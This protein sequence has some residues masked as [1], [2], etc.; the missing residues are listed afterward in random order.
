MREIAV[1]QSLPTRPL[2]RRSGLRTAAAAIVLA[3]ALTTAI[4]AGAQIEEIIVISRK[5]EERLQDVPIAVEAVSGEDI[6]RKGLTDIAKLAEQSASIKFD[7]GSSRQDTRLSIRGISPTRGRQNA[8]ILVDGIDISGE[9]VN[10]SGGSFNLSQQLLSLQRVEFLKGPQ[11]AL[12]GRSAFN[13]AVNFVTK[14]PTDIWE[15]TLNADANLE[16]QYQLTGEFSGPIL[17]EKL[18]IIVNGAW[19]DRDG[20]HDNSI[21]GGNI[22]WEEGYGFSVKTKSEFENG[23]SFSTRVYYENFEAGPSAEAFIPFNALVTQPD[24]AFQINNDPRLGTTPGAALYCLQDLLPPNDPDNPNEVVDRLVNQAWVD[25]WTALSRDPANPI[26]SDGPHC[27]RTIPFAL[28]RVPDGDELKAR[29]ATDPFNPGQDFE[30]IDGDTLRLSLI[31]QWE[32]EKGTFSSW[33]G[34]SNDENRERQDFG[35]AAVYDPSSPFLNSDFNSFINDSSRE[36]E[37]WHQEL[38]YA[39]NL[40]GPVQVALGINLWKEDVDFESLSLTNQAGNSTCF[41]SSGTADNADQQTFVTFTGNPCP[42]FTG[43]PIQPFLAGGAFTFGDG[44]PYEGIEQYLRPSPIGRETD[45]R[46]FYVDFDIDFDE[47]FNLH[48]EAR[49]NHEELEVTGPKFLNPNAGGGPG[50]WSICGLPFSACTT[51]F[52]FHAPNFYNSP[53]DLGG[54][55]WS[56]ANFML[57]SS[58]RALVDGGVNVGKSTGYDVWDPIEFPNLLNIIP[59]ECLA[60]PAVQ[61]RIERVENE[62]TDAF[63]LFNPF[64]VGTLSRTDDWFSPKATLTFKPNPDTTIYGY[65]ARAEKPGGFALFTVGASG[66]REDLSAYDPEK[67]VTYELG[68]KSKMLDGTLFVEGALFYN[69]YTDKQVLVQGLGPDGRSVSKIANAPAELFGGEISAQW[70]PE[71]SFLGGQWAFTGAYIYVDGQ[72][73]NFTDIATSENNIASAGNC[74]PDVL[75]DEV[76][77][78]VTGIASTRARPACRI[79]FDGNQFERSPKNSFVGTAGYTLPFAETLEF[80]SELGAQWKDKQFVEYTNENYLDAYWNVDLQFG[81]RGTRWEVLT[82]VN[83]LLDDDTV[84]S[85]S[86]QAGLGC[87]FAVGVSVDLGGANV[88]TGSGVDLPLAKAAFLPPP[89][90]IGMRARYKFGGED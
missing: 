76:I 43:L 31:G 58:R 60:D 38:R 80:F 61:R 50:S 84:R 29:L 72:Y 32:L 17:G 13:G 14:D 85:A 20:F 66:L 39:T 49:Y 7:Q 35:R 87:C 74:I 71:G 30:G 57:P 59:N 81:V 5:R 44:T 69:D 78:P 88:G 24:E 36:T 90:V 55:F 40:D 19:W 27:Q 70:R 23:L 16:D 48:L 64:C 34:Y 77:N 46:S 54:P 22:G 56:L 62:G 41:Y 8:A 45:H 33:T 83:N 51:E 86:N 63:D 65:I 68:A 15:A 89:R 37:Q 18:G 67:M 12:W 10:T 52:L 28:G 26:V 11:I 79:S 1:G 25:R 3:S 2:A 47:R 6:V 9:G 4:P 21:T 42:G 53:N 75:V 82:Y 73:K